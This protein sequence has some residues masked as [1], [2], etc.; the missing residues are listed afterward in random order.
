MEYGYVFC[1]FDV[2]VKVFIE[3]GLVEI[4]WIFIFV[5][6]YLNINCFWV[7]GKYKK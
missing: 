3:Y 7:L 4:V 2:W 1:R 5:L 6:G